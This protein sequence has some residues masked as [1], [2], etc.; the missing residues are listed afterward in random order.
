MSVR[1]CTHKWQK[2]SNLVYLRRKLLR[3]RWVKWLWALEA[4]FWEWAA[5]REA[6][7]KSCQ[8]AGHMTSVPRSPGSPAHSASPLPLQEPPPKCLPHS[9]PQPESASGHQLPIQ[10]TRR[11]RLLGWVHMPM[12]LCRRGRTWVFQHG[13]VGFVFCQDK[14]VRNPP[15]I[16]RGRCWTAIS[17]GCMWVSNRACSLEELKV[18]RPESVVKH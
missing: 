1:V 3:G 14:M 6:E 9:G 17:T 18:S 5:Q 8:R 16:R 15:N 10:I 13:E 4:R 12:S 2:K 11:V 7:P